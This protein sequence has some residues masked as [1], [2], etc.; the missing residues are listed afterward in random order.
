[1]LSIHSM[2]IG[3]NKYYEPLAATDYYSRPG[4]ES[5][6][7]CSSSKAR[8]LGLKGAVGKEAF[9]QLIRGYFPATGRLR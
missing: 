4:R 5:H 7:N 9:Q 3:S 6:G 8:P 1:M 2:P